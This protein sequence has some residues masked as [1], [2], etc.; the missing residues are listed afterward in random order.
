MNKAELVQRV[1]K[2]AGIGAKEAAT[3]VEAFTTAIKEALKA[4]ERVSLVGFGT[5]E[6]KTRAARNGVNPKTGQKIQIPAQTVP[7]FSPGKELRELGE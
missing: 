4:K 3:A 6:V 5:W 7:R 1:A 2:E